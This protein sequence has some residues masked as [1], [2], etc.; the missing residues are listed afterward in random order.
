MGADN[1]LTPNNFISIISNPTI[2]NPIN[3]NLL[4]NFFLKPGLVLKT[5]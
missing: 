4:I 5:N 1:F 2:S 3:E